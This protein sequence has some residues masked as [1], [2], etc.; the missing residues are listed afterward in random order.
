MPNSPCPVCC[1]PVVLYHIW[2]PNSSCPVYSIY[3]ILILRVWCDIQNL[4]YRYQFVY[5]IRYLVKGHYVSM[6]DGQ[7]D[8]QSTESAR[9]KIS[10]NHTILFNGVELSGCRTIGVLDYRGCPIYN[11]GNLIK[12]IIPILTTIHLYRSCYDQWLSNDMFVFRIESGFILRCMFVLLA[13]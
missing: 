11:T 9:S 8:V 6:K 5:S 2:M 13:L 10:K 7:F 1:I 4:L 3:I 12:Y